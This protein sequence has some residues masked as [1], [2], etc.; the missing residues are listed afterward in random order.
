MNID[1]DLEWF[2]SLSG[3][4]VRCNLSGGLRIGKESGS[5][6][7]YRVFKFVA[8]SFSVIIFPPLLGF[9]PYRVF[10]FVATWI[11][12][13]NRNTTIKGF[14][15][16]RVFKFVATSLNFRQTDPVYKFQSLSGF[17]VRCNALPSYQFER[18]DIVSIPIGFSSSLQPNTG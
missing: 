6:N 4:Q 13:N 15:P 5:F 18:D 10:K 2:Q 11:F 9:N 14:N 12:R 3:F 8:T 16:Y 1:A 17:Q 7:P